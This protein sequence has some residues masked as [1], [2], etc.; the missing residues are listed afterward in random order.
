MT[1]IQLTALAGA[2]AARTRAGFQQRNRMDLSQQAQ[3]DTARRHGP[4]RLGAGLVIDG[5]VIAA[6]DLVVD[7]RLS[8]ALNAPDHAVTIS[9]SATVRG[10][11]FAR[12]VLIEGTV[13]GEVTATGSI[14]VAERARVEA[15]LN[16]PS[17]AIA[18][19][20]F[21]VG[22]L[23]MRRADAAAR[24]ARYRIDRAGTRSTPTAAS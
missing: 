23:D 16:A 10:K 19:G 11:I 14:E 3:L 7:G 8:G 17:I 15:D 12:V 9:T 24:V 13:Q 20:A 21:V 1:G 22:K 2:A 6:E 18:L 5:E 4:G